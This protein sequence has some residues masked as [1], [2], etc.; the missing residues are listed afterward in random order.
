MG[1]EF[2]CSSQLTRAAPSKSCAPSSQQLQLPLEEPPHPATPSLCPPQLQLSCQG[3]PEWH[4]TGFLQAMLY[5]AILP[6]WPR[7]P[8]HDIHQEPLARTHS[9]LSHL[10]R[11]C[12]WQ[13][14][15]AQAHSRSSCLS[16]V[17]PAQYTLEPHD[18]CLLQRQSFYQSHQAHSL[19]RG[20]SSTRPHC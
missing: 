20:C 7:L 9:R 14:L 3:A 10:V 5:P 2:K 1:A 18:P 13:D 15:L 4:A 16:R 19:H 11:D 6:R 17:A 8:W 12:V